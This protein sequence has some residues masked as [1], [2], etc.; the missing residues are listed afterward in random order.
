MIPTITLNDKHKM[1]IL[2]L[3][4]WQSKSGQEV[5]QA[6]L[7]ALKNGYTHIDTAKIYGNE[8]SI[9]NAIKKSK[10]ARKNLFITTKIRNIDHSNVRKALESSLKKLQTDYVDLYLIHWPVKE[11]IQTWKVFEELQK[12]G[13]IKSIGVSNFTIRHLE[14]FKKH[15]KI[16]PAVNQVEFSPFLYQKELLDYCK[17]NQIQLVAYSPLAHAKKLEHKTIVSLAQKYNKTPAQIM[18]RWAIQHDVVVI[19]KSVKE[20]R[21]IENA[22]LFDFEIKAADMK[23]LDSL[24]E[25]YRTCW[26]PTNDKSKTIFNFSAF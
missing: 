14:E 3:G 9:G 8:E 19:P 5:E 1:P 2:G 24:N 25:N 6:V 15:T 22:Q 16:T 4:T 20:H 18:L 13:K 7:F 17:K 23:I 26:D 10:I 12:S 21:I 11:S